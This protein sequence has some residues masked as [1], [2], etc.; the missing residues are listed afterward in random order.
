MLPWNSSCLKRGWTREKKKSIYN[1]QNQAIQLQIF[2]KYLQ[3]WQ[4]KAHNHKIWRRNLLLVSPFFSW[5]SSTF[6]ELWQYEPLL[7]AI[8][9]GLHSLKKSLFYWNILAFIAISSFWRPADIPDKY[10]HSPG[11]YTFP[12]YAEDSLTTI[13]IS[14]VLIC[15]CLCFR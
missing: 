5:E 2:I 8:Y 1:I 11:T 14:I 7:N 10:S 3:A 9:F 13:Q 6:L 4:K 15:R 12:P